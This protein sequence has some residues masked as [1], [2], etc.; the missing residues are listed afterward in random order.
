MCTVN[1]QNRGGGVYF[2]ISNIKCKVCILV[3][4]SKSNRHEFKCKTEFDCLYQ[5]QTLFQSCFSVFFQC[6]GR[7]GFYSIPVNTKPFSLE[8]IRF[9]WL[10]CYSGL[11][12]VP[13]KVHWEAL[14]AVL[15]EECFPLLYKFVHQH[16]GSDSLFF[17]T[18]PDRIR[19][20]RLLWVCT[21]KVTGQLL[22]R[23]LLRLSRLSGRPPLFTRICFTFFLLNNQSASRE[24][25]HPVRLRHT[26]AEPSAEGHQLNIK[27]PPFIPRFINSIICT[28]EKTNMLLL[29]HCYYW[30]IIIP[31]HIKK[32]QLSPFLF[33]FCWN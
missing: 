14:K 18:P 30:S 8:S 17:L 2:F 11:S 21:V 26:H 33:P 32:L 29:L 3:F 7:K 23:G 6:A 22:C 27:C 19:Q 25:T 4:G 24:E 9:Y 16:P 15:H 1:C 10:S 5:A 12:V 13:W 20:S 28:F 31:V